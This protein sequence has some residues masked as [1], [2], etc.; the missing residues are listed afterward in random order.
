MAIGY[1][2]NNLD[3]AIFVTEVDGALGLCVT[4]LRA[5]RWAGVA[6]RMIQSRLRMGTGRRSGWIDYFD[7]EVE[8]QWRPVLARDP[9]ASGQRVASNRWY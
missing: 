2:T 3:I 4:G 8:I 6:D 9:R 1:G 5:H 7:A